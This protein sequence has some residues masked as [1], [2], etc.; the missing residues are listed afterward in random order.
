MKKYSVEKEQE[1]WSDS[2]R[3]N[4]SGYSVPTRFP[5]ACNYTDLQAFV[6]DLAKAQARQES[7]LDWKWEEYQEARIEYLE[8]QAET[9]A[10]REE[11]WF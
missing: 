1:Q 8:Q 4:Q 2:N 10:E 11:M 7:H 5:E 6:I 3:F 9:K